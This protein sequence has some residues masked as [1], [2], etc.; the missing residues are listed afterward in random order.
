MRIVTIITF[1]I[2]TSLG[3]AQA[4]DGARAD[5]ALPPPTG[6]LPVGRMTCHLTDTAR[7]ETLAAPAGKQRELMVYLWYPAA[8]EPGA[9]RACYFP[10][11]DAFERCVGETATK[12]LLGEAGRAC[13]RSGALKAHAVENAKISAVA[14]K[15]PLLVFSPGFDESCITYSATLAELASHG[16]LVAAIDHP[17]DA[18]CVNFPDGRAV[19][20]A[21]EKWDAATKSTAS[22]MAYYGARIEVWAADTRFVLDQLI[23]Q[24]AGSQPSAVFGERIDR[25]RIGIFGHSVGG[26]TA[27][28]ASELDRRFRACMNGDSDYDG[29]PFMPVTAPERIT[30]PF[31]FF[32]S[33]H[34]SYAEIPSLTDVQLKAQRLTRD[35]YEKI[36]RR[37]QKNQDDAL[38][39]MPGG[40]CRVCVRAPRFMHRSFIDA[41]VLKACDDPDKQVFAQTVRNLETVRLYTRAF[42]D[43]HLKGMQNTLLDREPAPELKVKIDR[44]GAGNP[45]RGRS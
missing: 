21:Q 23:S 1:L 19:K 43:K 37:F 32:V 18:T 6:P 8:P 35:E 34:S 5:S 38:A 25:E 39:A 27:A 12:K 36:Y 30:R 14:K 17:Y 42:F 41:T 45:G 2:G 16:Y 44:F 22:M 20:F 28:R 29:R 4:A 13:A 33:E 40:S 11:F 7:Q 31:L 15:F 3:A 24:R 26:M 9:P 10:D